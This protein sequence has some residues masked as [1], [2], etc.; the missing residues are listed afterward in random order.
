MSAD[1]T[2]PEELSDRVRKIARDPLRDL[3]VGGD[4]LMTEALERA[5][6]ALDAKD[7]T[8]EALTAEHDKAMALLRE[9]A[10]VYDNCFWNCDQWNECHDECAESWREAKADHVKAREL[11]LRTEGE[12]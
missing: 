9:A 6:D 10:T 12:S 3:L 7:R 5:A 4:D 2:T 1:R 11:F 8:I